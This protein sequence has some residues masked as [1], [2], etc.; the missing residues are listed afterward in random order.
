[1]SRKVKGIAVGGTYWTKT[2][3]PEQYVVEEI[4]SSRLELGG[5]RVR[6]IV[7]GYTRYY[8][9]RRLRAGAIR[10]PFQKAVFGRGFIGSGEFSPSDASGKPSPEY[11]RWKAILSRCYNPIPHAKDLSYKDCEVCEEWLNF[12]NF[13]GWLSSQEH[14]KKGYE[15]DK[16]LLVPGNKVYGPETCCMLPRE[17]NTAITGKTDSCENGLPCGVHWHRKNSCYVVSVVTDTE[18][19]QGSFQCLE[20]AIEVSKSTKEAYIKRLAEKYKPTISKEVYEA[21]CKYEYKMYPQNKEIK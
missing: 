15:I 21:L 5:I 16:D 17:V 7:G 8:D 9:G 6:F 10:S 20:K 4:L 13:A 12:Q 14:Y 19:Y 18:D 2:K 3:Y 1:M 11:R